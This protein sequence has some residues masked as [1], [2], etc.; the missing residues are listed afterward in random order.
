MRNTV[1]SGARPA[2]ILTF[3]TYIEQNFIDEPVELVI[4]LLVNPLI[5]LEFP[6]YK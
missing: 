3:L 6:M 4:G 5:N 1:R 2:H